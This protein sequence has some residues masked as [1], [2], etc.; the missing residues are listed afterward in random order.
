[1]CTRRV[2]FF[3]HSLP[4]LRQPIDL[5]TPDGASSPKTPDA[6]DMPFTSSP[7]R[8]QPRLRPFSP[9]LLANALQHMS[10]MSLDSS[11][12]SS[13]SML[14]RYSSNEMSTEGT[15]QLSSDTEAALA[16]CGD[17]TAL[18]THLQ[19]LTAGAAGSQADPRGFSGFRAS[20]YE[21]LDQWISLLTEEN[22]AAAA[23][24]AARADE[25]QQQQ[26]QYTRVAA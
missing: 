4:E 11:S 8:Q 14:G 1:M 9:S 15:S 7:G 23:N 18:L 25:Q 6:S 10:S 12:S 13:A 22:E 17:A 20:S 19:S 24:W 21:A 5:P 2:C 26:Q 16:N 3:A